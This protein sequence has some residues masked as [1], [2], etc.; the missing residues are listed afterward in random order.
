MDDTTTTTTSSSDNNI[1]ISNNKNSF[2]SKTF[3]TSGYCSYDN[4]FIDVEAPAASLAIL[5]DGRPRDDNTTINDI[6][7]DNVHAASIIVLDKML[8]PIP[9]CAL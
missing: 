4:D 5:M 3:C 1:I 9:T 8:S 2:G 7:N 6:D